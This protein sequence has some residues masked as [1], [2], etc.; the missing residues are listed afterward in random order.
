[1]QTPT[2]PDCGAA[3][4]Q[5]RKGATLAKRGPAYVCPMAESGRGKRT[6]DDKHTYVRVWTIDELAPQQ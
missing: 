1:M 2:C 3:L 4:R 5:T 6:A